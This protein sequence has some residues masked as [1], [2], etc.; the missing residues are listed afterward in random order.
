MKSTKWQVKSAYDPWI[1]VSTAYGVQ[2]TACPLK[3]EPVTRFQLVCHPCSLKKHIVQC[4]VIKIR[5]VSTLNK[6]RFSKKYSDRF[7]VYFEMFTSFVNHTL[8]FKM[9]AYLCRCL[10]RYVFNVW[11]SASTWIIFQGV[12]H[13]VKFENRCTKW[14]FIGE[15]EW[16]E[17]Q[18]YH[19]PWPDWEN[20]DTVT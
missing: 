9:L 8:W 18:I 6:I 19:L 20:L 15:C 14:K 2:K 5:K 1:D 10:D 11:W 16:D 17:G 4:Y 3:L 13:C 7:K 12:R